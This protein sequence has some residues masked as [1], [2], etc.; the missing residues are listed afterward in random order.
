MNCLAD[1]SSEACPIC[2]PANS[3]L[4]C[5]KH[6]LVIP[7]GFLSLNLSIF[8]MWQRTGS[9]T[10]SRPVGCMWVNSESQLYWLLNTCTPVCT[11]DRAV[12]LLRRLA[13]DR[14]AS[15]RWISTQVQTS[16]RP[17]QDAYST[18]WTQRNNKDQQIRTCM[19]SWQLFRVVALYRKRII[20]PSHPIKL[21]TCIIGAWT[22]VSLVFLLLDSSR[23]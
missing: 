9:A 21:L 23:F 20:K 5:C 6:C 7:S 2:D 19:P 18:C 13:F 22:E 8:L 14:K 4:L 3:S 10:I 12:H 1:P 11:V 15:S 17:N 16:G